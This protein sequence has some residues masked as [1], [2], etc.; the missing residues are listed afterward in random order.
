MNNR[1]ILTLV[2]VLTAML[3][4]GNAMAQV[5]VHGNVYGGGNAADVKINTEVNIS[6]GQVDGNV[7]GGGNLGDVG[8]HE[9]IT[10][11]LC[12]FRGEYWENCSSASPL[13]AK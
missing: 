4:G 12:V 5:K 11:E 1:Y 13:V 2:L 6:A 9:D 8:T 3:A 7:Y 10:G